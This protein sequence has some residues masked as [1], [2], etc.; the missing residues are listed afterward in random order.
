MIEKLISFLQWIQSS[1]RLRQRLDIVFSYAFTIAS[2]SLVYSLLKETIFQTHSYY[3][4]RYSDNYLFLDSR[5]AD[6]VWW[7]GMILC[8]L[9]SM[10]AVYIYGI[11]KKGKDWN[12]SL[13]GLILNTILPLIV[14]ITLVYTSIT[15][16]QV[17]KWYILVFGWLY[18]ISPFIAF[19]SG[20]QKLNIGWGEK[21]FLYSKKYILSFLIGLAVFIPLYVFWNLFGELRYL[22][23]TV[24]VPFLFF[25]LCIY[26]VITWIILSYAWAEIPNITETSR[27]RIV[28]VGL[29]MAFIFLC[30]WLM[31]N[32]KDTFIENRI[33]KAYSILWDYGA[34]KELYKEAESIWFLDWAMREKYIK[35]NLSHVEKSLYARIFDTAIEDTIHEKVD[36]NQYRSWNSNATNRLAQWENA[37][38]ELNFA[39]H[40]TEVLPDIQAAK[41]TITYEFQNTTTSNQEVIFSMELPNSASTVTDLKLGLNL[42]YT[43]VIAP[44]GAASR[45]YQDSLRRNTDPALLEQTGPLTYRLR[46]FPVPGN[47]DSKTQGRQRV[48][49]SYITPLESTKN[50]T[51]IPKTEILNLKLTKKS[52]I[53]TRVTEE[54][55]ALVQDSKMGDDLHLLTDGKIEPI[56]IRAGKNF[57]EYCTTNVYP[58]IDIQ[59]FSQSEKKLTK[60]MV[61]FDISKSIGAKP[62]IQQEYQSLINA[63]KNNGISLDVFTYNFEVYPSGYDISGVDFWGTTNMSKIID[64]ID[65]NNISGANIVI[66]TDDNSYEQSEK[67][68]KNID[69]KKL[70]TNRISLIQIGKNIRTLKT[71]ITKSILATNGSMS[72]LEPSAPISEGIKNIFT[73]TPSIQS[74][75]TYTGSAVQPLKALQGYIDSKKIFG[76]TYSYTGY[77]VDTGSLYRGGLENPLIQYLL[78][79]SIMDGS[80]PLIF[81]E[82]WENQIF[83]SWENNIETVYPTYQEFSIFRKNIRGKTIVTIRPEYSTI[84]V[85]IGGGFTGS[86]YSSGRSILPN[87][88]AQFWK[89]IGVKTPIQKQ[90]DENEVQE[91]IAQTSHIVN[92]SVSLIALETE[93]QKQDLER[94]SGNSDKYDTNYENFETDWVSMR[95]FDGFRDITIGSTKSEPALFWGDSVMSSQSLWVENT[96]FGILG[97]SRSGVGLI[98]YIVIILCFPLI[99]WFLLRKKSKTGKETASPIS[100]DDK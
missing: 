4:D 10:V 1:E 20:F 59:K 89:D 60:N 62:S 94:Y 30:I 57:I 78:S 42:E 74:C 2:I 14:G 64:Y 5:L 31:P 98:Q 33:E 85:E 23:L 55:K 68:I 13:I 8:L 12:F 15:E 80:D 48:Q 34:T 81:L 63:W 44:R 84:T 58:N 11:Y 26:S 19:L 67:E 66:V 90:L 87:E 72:V 41:T 28:R 43:W 45:V 56:T 49:W 27:E 96:S 95:S 3:Y 92:Q 76:N 47:N 24:V 99:S 38:V 50:I 65:K 17:I 6:S 91:E 46:V 35:G 53:L 77:I 29:G 16:S 71:E 21:I 39:K 88:I 40:E 54:E 37:T 83:S 82:N 22:D 86:M 52:E 25:S 70:K 51:T 93:R 100:S 18:S 7:T 73:P 32:W 75:E 69:Y 97:N 36:M 79:G 9:F 61:F